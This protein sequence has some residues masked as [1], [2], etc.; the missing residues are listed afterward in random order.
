MT[1]LL[2]TIKGFVTRFSVQ[3]VAAALLGPFLAWLVVATLPRHIESPF[4]SFLITT[5]LGFGGMVVGIGVDLVNR[6]N[7]RLKNC[8]KEIHAINHIYR[9]ALSDLL[10]SVSPVE[11]SARGEDHGLLFERSILNRVCQRVANLFGNLTGRRCVVTV[12]LAVVEKDE[13]FCFTWARSQADI[14]REDEPWRKYSLLTG[15]NTGF[16]EALK[17][18]PNGAS[19][20][21]QTTFGQTTHIITSEPVGRDC[22]GARLS[23]RFGG[24][25]NVK[26]ELI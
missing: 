3:L 26:E 15:T 17:M 21:F 23:F 9:D 6:D 25:L 22:T 19:H 12:K 14:Y 13:S 5:V 24:F 1:Y 16:D 2:T 10:S 20:F 11:G 8:A 18:R 7:R 4:A